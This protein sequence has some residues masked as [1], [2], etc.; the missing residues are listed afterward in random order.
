MLRKFYVIGPLAILILA[1]V[2]CG[3]SSSRFS[4][5]NNPPVAN[6]GPDQNISTNSLVILDGSLSKDEDGDFLTYT[7]SLMP[8][9]PDSTAVLSDVLSVRPTFTADVDGKYTVTLVVNDGDVNSI[10]DSVIITA[11]STNSAPVAVASPDQ[12]V[13]TLSTVILD[14]SGSSDADLDTLTYNWSFTSMPAGSTAV[15]SSASVVNPTFVADLDGS[16]V[17]QLTV[18]DGSVDSAADTVIIT[19]ATANSAPVANAGADQNVNTASTV[20]LDGSGSSDADLDALTYNWNFNSKPGGSVAVLSSTT[21]VNPTFNPDVD[22]AYVLQL[23]VNDG[24]VDSA[25]D[26]VIITSATANSTP[27]ADA[28]PDQN[29]NTASTV[30]MDGSGSSDA[31]L[32]T[33][34]YSWSFNSKP[35]SSVAVLSSTTS[36]NPTFNPDVDGAYVLQLIVNDG[37]VDSTVDTVIITSATANSTPVADAGPDQNVN[38]AS[39][40]TLDGSGS[41]DA[42]MDTLTYKWNFNSKP[43]SSVAVLS[44]TTSVNPTFNP[45][46]D[47]TYVLQLTVNDGSVD[48]AIDTVT[49]T[50]ATANSTPVADAGP[51]QNVNTA[52]TVTLDGSGSSDADMDT[53]TYNWSFTSR[54]ANS[55]SV[56]LTTIPAKPTFVADLDGA[57]VLQLI[58]NDGSVESVADSVIITALTPVPET[59]NVSP[60][61]ETAP[62]R[63]T[64]DAADDPAIWVHPTDPELSA[65][66][67]TN[68]LGGIAVYNLDGSEHQYRADGK[69]NN[70]DIRY[71]FSLGGN[72]VDLVGM[73]NR[74]NDTLAF[75][76]MNTSTRKLTSVGSVSTNLTVYGFCMYK[77]SVTGKFYAFVNSTT[78]EVE[79]YELSD[80]NGNVV[81][82]LVRSFSVGSIT[83]GC[84]ADDEFG[85]FYIGEENVSIWKYGAEPADGSSRVSVDSEGSH[86]VADV[87]GLT[88]YHTTGGKG[89]LIASS[90]GSDRYVLYDRVTNDYVGSFK[91]IAGNGIDGTTGTDGIDVISTPLGP[92][93]PYG[94]F[95]TQDNINTG[96]N[97]N[98]K[99]VKW[100]D[101]AQGF[102]I[103]LKM[104]TNWN[105]RNVP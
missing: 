76:T 3:D 78:G 35:G 75:Y 100:E 77:S 45:D 6:A 25:A 93:F 62:V 103:N 79:Q 64:G 59:I 20:R 85:N 99:I 4:D 84:V 41:S 9:P 63:S 17:L 30:T 39:T 29:V 49:I 65:I 51:D 36:V 82:N 33:L 48:S 40:V 13:S 37:S 92:G 52:S 43:G 18:N 74:T 28:G 32:D 57:Y 81:G 34:T 91:V 70:V 73:S 60:V 89:Y 47:G 31:D 97:Q 44:S 71:G 69:M 21:S 94:I 38:T 46:V 5:N 12:N 105:P 66:I 98:Y 101:I 7:W 68:K 22:G 50:S 96:S 95:V 90:Q 27:V 102:T 10:A 86:F 24:S 23:I 11:A 26:T 19:T 61:V 15:L 14:G 53:L 67:G 104:E 83:E 1:N 54:P 2:S 16:Y 87:E 42:D 58:V 88:I 8:V 80:N 55:N 56:L 72:L